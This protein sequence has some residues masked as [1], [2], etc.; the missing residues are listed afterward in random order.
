MIFPGAFAISNLG[1]LYDVM[2]IN[3]RM[4]L[5]WLQREAMGFPCDKIFRAVHRNTAS[6]N[7]SFNLVLSKPE[8]LA[9]LLID[10]DATSM[11]IYEVSLRVSPPCSRN[12]PFGGDGRSS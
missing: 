6:F 7:L 12:N 3:V 9:G 4:T 5:D 11:R 10:R 8:E 1:S 2:S